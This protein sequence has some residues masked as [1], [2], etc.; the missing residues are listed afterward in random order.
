MVAEIIVDFSACE[1]FEVMVS[2]RLYYLYYPIESTRG[3]WKKIGLWL[4][5]DIAG[6]S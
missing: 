2:K 6:R 3:H 1:R 4:Y 5:I